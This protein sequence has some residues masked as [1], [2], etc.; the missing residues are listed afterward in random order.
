M[1]SSYSC[2]PNRNLHHH[3]ISGFRL[4][5][6]LVRTTPSRGVP[7]HGLTSKRGENALRSHYKSVITSPLPKTMSDFVIA[8]QRLARV[9]ATASNAIPKSSSQPDL[10]KL[11]TT[12]GWPGI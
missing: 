2:S 7:I 9:S 3:I 5:A 10:G 11:I 1:E 4:N 8:T 12:Y 6:P